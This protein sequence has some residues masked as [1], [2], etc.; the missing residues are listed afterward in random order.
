VREIYAELADRTGVDP[1]WNSLRDHLSTHAR[2]TG[3]PI[4]RVSHGR[5]A[6]KAS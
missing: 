1:S 5:Y 2:T 3:S 4:Y 6:L